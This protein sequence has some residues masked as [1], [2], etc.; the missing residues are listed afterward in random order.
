MKKVKKTLPTKGTGQAGAKKGGAG[1]II[2]VSEAVEDEVRRREA[3]HYDKLYSP[4]GARLQAKILERVR[5]ERLAK[6][7]KMAGVGIAFYFKG[8]LYV[9]WTPYTVNPSYSGYRTHRTGHPEYWQSL[10]QAGLVP[11]NIPYQ[12][13]PRARA[14]YEVSTEQFTLFA[15]RCIFKNK[16][17]IRA[18]KRQLNLPPST[19][20]VADRHYQ[21]FRCFQKIPPKWGVDGEWEF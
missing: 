3:N 10:Q 19:R 12:W 6:G 1:Q 13:V 2:M 20:V 11:W 17:K 14:T 15:D 16:R 9:S 8:K 7:K 4:R 5:L 21:C 18:I